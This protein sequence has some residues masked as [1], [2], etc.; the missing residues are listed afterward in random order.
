MLVVLYL[1]FGFGVGVGGVWL[2]WK[3]EVDSIKV[4]NTEITVI[5]KKR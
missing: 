1:H 4:G 5:P 3:P 2:G